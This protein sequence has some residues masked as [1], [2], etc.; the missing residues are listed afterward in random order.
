MS[1]GARERAANPNLRALN[2]ANA[3]SDYGYKG[4]SANKPLTV[5]DDGTKTWFR[6]EGETPPF[7][8]RIHHIRGH[9]LRRLFSRPRKQ[10][11]HIQS[12]CS[13]HSRHFFIP[14][15]RLAQLHLGQG[16]QRH[17]GQ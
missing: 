1:L 11:A 16:G 13:R 10:L 12:H 7:D 6:F 14:H 2:I 3:N 5:F 9:R 17:T 4:S 15:G 8:P